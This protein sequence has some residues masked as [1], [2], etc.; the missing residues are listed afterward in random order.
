M[1]YS[2]SG[3][4]FWQAD[5]TTRAGAHTA[6]RQASIACFVF[7]GFCVVGALAWGGAAGL[8]TA[9]GIGSMIG[10]GIEAAIGLIAGLRLRSGKG[11]Y[12][13][14]LTA[15]LL[16]IEL[17]AKLIMLSL[18]GLILP[19]ILLVL[20]VQGVRGAR[21]LSK[22]VGFDDDDVDVFA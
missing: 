11:F 8:E 20:I 6:T 18:L 19:T 14:A 4:G 21:A 9:Q 15:L 5:L 17:L 3:G 2:D 10:S 12:W 22:N 1:A 7:A 13:G 16:A